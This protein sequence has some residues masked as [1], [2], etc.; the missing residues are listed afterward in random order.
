MLL[1][2]F[3]A[4][5]L[6]ELPYG[7]RNYAPL[8]NNVQKTGIYTLAS[9]FW[10]NEKKRRHVVSFQWCRFRSGGHL[11]ITYSK[12]QFTYY[13]VKQQPRCIWNGILPSYKGVFTGVNRSKYSS[14]TFL[15][16]LFYSRL[17]SDLSNV[18]R[19]YAYCH[20]LWSFHGCHVSSSSG[21]IRSSI[22]AKKTEVDQNAFLLC[23]TKIRL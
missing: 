6:T 8:A 21:K 5:H 14:I 10:T 15:C 16:F 12:H 2:A 3:E 1:R 22:M 11:E 18:E 4:L 23:L 19:T 13:A 7:V 17:P 20:I 9:F